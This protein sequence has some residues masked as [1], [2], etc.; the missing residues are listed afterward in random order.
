MAKKRI[1]RTTIRM[2]DDNGKLSE[3]DKINIYAHTKKEFES[4][5]RKAY[6]E[7][8]RRKEREKNAYFGDW[9]NKWLERKSGKSKGTIDQYKA[10]IKHLNVEFENVPLKEIKLDNFEEF[11][12][13]L[14]Q[15]P[16]ANNKTMSKR[17]LVSV[18]KTARSIFRYAIDHEVSGVRDFFGSVDIDELAPYAPEKKRSALSE[19]EIQWIIDTEHR[20][21]LPAMIM[22]F[23]GLRR[24]ELIPLKWSDI[25]FVRKT[26]AVNKSVFVKNDSNQLIIKEGGKTKS[27]KRTVPLPPILVDFL[28]DY[29]AKQAELYPT[30]CVT[31]HNKMHTNS[32]WRRMWDSYSELLN[33]KYCYDKKQLE[34]YK[35][36]YPKKKIPMKVDFSA[37]Y[38]RHMYA[39]LLFLQDVPEKNAKQLLGHANY[40]I[41]SD[42]YTDLEK[43]SAFNISNDFKM[44]LKNEY[45]IEYKIDI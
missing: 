30:V 24:G 19:D 6:E 35:K 28:K 29:K 12:K 9:A 7:R 5:K 21:Q 45:K 43:Y 33:E 10:A 34:E 8:E 18:K 2:Y 20:A 14:A 39:T 15:T 25:D 41:T 17:T 1:Y 44:K 16:T 11:V 37:H 4:K 40:A 23:T 27:A 3:K 36:K 38:L 26:L 22:L 13:K 32:S 42:I 31:A